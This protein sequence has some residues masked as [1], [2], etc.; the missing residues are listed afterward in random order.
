[1][2]KARSISRLV[3]EDTFTVS[4][5][6]A[7]IGVGTAEPTSKLNVAGIVSATGF[8]GDG[9]TLSGIS[10]NYVNAA[11]ISTYS[12]S[13]GIAT[14]AQTAG[15]ATV[16]TGLSG[17]PNI[18]VGIATASSFVGNLTGTATTATTAINANVASYS[19]L[20]GISTLSEGL[21]GTPNIIVGIITGSSA[22]FSGNVSIAG[23]LTYEDV[24]N[25]DSVGLITARNGLIVNSGVSTISGGANFNKLLKEKVNIV[26]G[27]LS[28]NPNINLENGMVHLFTTTETTTSTPNIRY[29]ASTSLNSVMSVGEAISITIITSSSSAGYSP[30]INIDGSGVTENWIGG[31]APISGGTSGIDIYTY[32][33]I[34][35]ASATYTV[36]ANR[37]VTS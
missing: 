3:G 31:S 27:K 20:S 36:I 5:V 7:S 12:Q 18:I 11:G 14:Y 26:S 28:D 16:A 25:V 32:I 22:S 8:Y 10:T 15:I 1:M 29:N 30:D 21:S 6:P 24:T 2:S 9:S 35:I 33:I 23:T 13:A 19:P 37:T 34:K 4:G 17:T